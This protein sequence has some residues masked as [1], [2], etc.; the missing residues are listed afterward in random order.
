MKDTDLDR[1]FYP[2]SIAV[3]GASSGGSGTLWGGNT[4]LEGSIRMN[5]KGRLYPVNPRAEYI[6]GMKAYHNILEIPDD[7]DLAI[8]SIPYSA[9]LPV[10]RQCAQKRV[11]FVHLF[12]AGFSETGHEEN[13]A[14]EKEIIRLAQES[15]TRIIGPNCMGI[16]SPEGGVAWTN[17][18]P[19]ESGP[20]GFFS[21]S[22][23]LA[24]QI[25]QDGGH[26]GVFFSKAV[27]FG[28][29]ADLQAVD[30][31]RYFMKDKKISIVGAYLE[32][33]KD[34]QAFFEAAREMT[35]AKP[36]IIWK[37]G[38]TEGGSRAAQSHT[39]AIAGSP[40]V[41]QGLC[42]QSGIISVSSMEELISC[43]S[44]LKKIQLPKGKNVAVLGGAGGG[45]VTMTD[46][47]EREGLRVPRLSE[48][49]IKGLREFV[50]MQGSSVQNPLDIMQSL[51]DMGNFKKLMVLL[52]TDPRIDALIF[53]LKLDLLLRVA[54]RAILDSFVKI[55]TDM[56]NHLG[57]P[58][59]IVIERADSLVEEKYRE[60]ALERFNY[61]GMA[62]F[63]SFAMAARVLL[64][65]NEYHD[66][67]SSLRQRAPAV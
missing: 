54:G 40:R 39:A 26:D 20:F 5:F 3:I 6:L 38:Q 46:V 24:G 52:R 31:L 64:H 53:S 51:L 35:G 29:A 42:K 61:A 36:L 44:A 27:S 50:P 9:A 32:G 11:K 21:Q 4:Y 65:M 66:Y 34:G 45:S 48:H 18:F 56:I 41:W 13:I 57:K 55:T 59:F 12:T 23:Q 14:L 2:E 28:N 19:R 25:I 15:G 16:Y 49:T 22:G 7:I 37:G 8:F 1:L 63:S 43:L 33:L 58:A 30:F 10:M 47:A 17:E 60:A 67:L 62:T